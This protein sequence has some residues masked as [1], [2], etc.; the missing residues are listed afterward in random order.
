ML[1]NEITKEGRW[2]KVQAVSAVW[3]CKENIIWPFCPRWK[4]RN[5]KNAIYGRHQRLASAL[6]F[7]FGAFGPWRSLQLGFIISILFRGSVQLKRVQSFARSHKVKVS[8]TWL[9][10]NWKGGIKGII[11]FIQCSSVASGLKIIIV[12]TFLASLVML[13]NL[14]LI[15]DFGFWAEPFSICPAVLNLTM[16]QLH[17]LPHLWCF[18][19]PH[20]RYHHRQVPLASQGENLRWIICPTRNR[21]RHWS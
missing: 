8:L 1:K 12:W 10:E 7:I 20:C 16:F 2:P 4:K 21:A 5:E 13:R 15:K 3:R 19:L 6:C 11:H 17:V 14:L 9:E 18:L